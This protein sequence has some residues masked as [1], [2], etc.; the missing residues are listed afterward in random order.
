MIN[1]YSFS[2]AP[3]SSRDIKPAHKYPNN[4]GVDGTELEPHPTFVVNTIMVEVRSIICQAAE[5][6]FLT[7]SV[8]IGNIDLA[9]EPI[10]VEKIES[11]FT[12]LN[13]TLGFITD[14]R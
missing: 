3:L 2:H 12:H 1:R 10:S 7:A 8:F 6:S 4:Q 13:K 11:F 9:K 14:Y 5:N